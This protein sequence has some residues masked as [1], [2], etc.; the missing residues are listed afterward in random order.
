MDMQP[1]DTEALNI[2]RC[3]VKVSDVSH[4]L[5]RGAGH[6]VDHPWRM[7][8]E[9]THHHRGRP[10][11]CL[12]PCRMKKERTGANSEEGKERG[13]RRKTRKGPGQADGGVGSWMLCQSQKVFSRQMAQLDFCP[14]K[15]GPTNNF[16][17]P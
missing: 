5:G 1:K 13:L 17:S 9:G 11:S 8:Q 15:L 12:R 7:Q 14:S 16:S 6:L 3:T 2:C 10:R 4:G